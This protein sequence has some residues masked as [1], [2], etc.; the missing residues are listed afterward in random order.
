MA[1]K[2]DAGKPPK[3]GDKPGYRIASGSDDAEEDT[4]GEVTLDSSDLE[5]IEEKTPQI[6]GL[7]FQAINIPR[8]AKIAKAYVQFQTNERSEGKASLNICAQAIDDAPTFTTQD[9]DLSKRKRTAAVVG[10]KPDSWKKERASGEKQRT[11]N[12]ASVIQ[13][14]VNRPGWKRGNALALIIT[15]KGRRVADSYDGNVDAAPV[16]TVK[17]EGADAANKAVKKAP[18]K[19]PKKKQ[20]TPTRYALRLYFAEPKDI[21]PGQRVFDVVMQGKTV[22]KGLDI[23]AQADGARRVIFREF[24]HVE[25][26]RDLTVSLKAVAGSKH[27]P[28]LSGIEVVAEK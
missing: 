28:I 13:A 19:Q 6:V 23:A 16:L 21:A 8:G 15:G 25:V 18:K 7:R 17:L 1:K 27:P 24:R 11:P 3:G 20:A 12:L 9:K 10:W 5:L 22:L 14:I 2:K 4:G 26:S